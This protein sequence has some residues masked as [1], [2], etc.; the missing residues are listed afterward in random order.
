MIYEIHGCEKRAG[1]FAGM[2]RHGSGRIAGEG[3]GVVYN[4]VLLHLFINK[5]TLRVLP[6]ANIWHF[7]EKQNKK[8]KKSSKKAII[9]FFFPK[10]P[11]KCHPVRD[12]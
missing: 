1:D 6:A 4:F 2:E 10:S 11:P 8:P 3:G 12:F 7:F 9:S 5:K